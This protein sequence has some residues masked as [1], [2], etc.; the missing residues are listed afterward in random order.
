MQTCLELDSAPILQS[1]LPLPRLYIIPFARDLQFDATTKRQ[2]CQHNGIRGRR[3]AS[4]PESAAYLPELR[5]LYPDTKW[6]FVYRKAEDA[7]TKTTHRKRNSICIKASRNPS[8][9]PSARLDE[10][11]VDVDKLAHHKVCALHL[12]TQLDVVIREHNETGTGML[13][14][15]G[16]DILLNVNA[17]VDVILPYLSLHDEIHSDPQSVRDHVSEILSVRSNTSARHN[18]KD[19]Q[20]NVDGEKIGV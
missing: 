14:S 20:H 19:K 11:N 18:H 9:K 13:I 8:A 6:G 17:I 7:L 10:Y 1:Y 3:K 15:Y 4:E 5:S 16:D 12:S 2:H